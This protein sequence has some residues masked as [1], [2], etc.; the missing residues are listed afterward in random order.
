[1][2][3]TNKILE[4]IK[5]TKQCLFPYN[6]RIHVTREKSRRVSISQGTMLY[7][8]EIRICIKFDDCDDDNSRLPKKKHM[9]GLIPILIP[10]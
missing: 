1:M 8:T 2:T 10:K 6:Y 9:R 4:I 5:F 3:R 7:D